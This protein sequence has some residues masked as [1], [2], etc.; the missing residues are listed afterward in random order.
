MG[1]QHLADTFQV[2]PGR[3]RLSGDFSQ[4]PIDVLHHLPLL[5]EIITLDVHRLSDQLKEV[6]DLERIGRFMGT[7]LSMACMVNTDQTVYS[8]GLSGSELPRMK[9]ALILGDGRERVAHVADPRLL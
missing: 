7:E 1:N 6:D 8:Y 5:E 4:H 3:N 2:Q 9:F